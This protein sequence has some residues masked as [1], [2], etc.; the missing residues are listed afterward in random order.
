MV[1][2]RVFIP[3]LELK[4]I[5]ENVVDE[6]PSYDNVQIETTYIFGT[7]D[8]LSQNWDA[9]ILVARGMTHDV[10]RDMFPDKHVVQIQ[11][12][13]F[14]IFD[15]LV[16]CRK[17]QAKKIALCL[18]NVE[19]HN[20]DSLQELCGAS[21]RMYDVADEQSAEAAVCEAASE[22]ADT[23]VGA[24]TMCG[25][26]DRR[27][28]RRVHIH[29][30]HDAV[31][32]AMQEALNA[33]K[34][35]NLE[36]T[37]SE[38]IN[39]MLN[40][41]EDGIIAIDDKGRILAI[42]N[43]AYRVFQLSTVGELIGQPLSSVG[44]SGEWKQLLENGSGK[45][46]IICLH[47][48]KYYVQYKPL[49]EMEAGAGALIFIKN[50]DRIIE[51]ESRI[52]R[53][54]S[55]KGLTAKYTFEDILGQSAAIRENIRMA[56]RYSGV[57]SNVLIIGETGTGKELFAHSIHQ[58]SKRSHQP[59][60]AL[61]CAALP[62][63]LL[64]SELFGYEA[65]AFSGASKGGKTGLFEL[66]HKGTIF[67]DEIGEIPITL[68]AKLLRVLQEKEIRRIG[69]TSVHPVDVRVISAT[70]INMEE[71]IKE[72]QFRSD[73]YYRLNLLDI[74]I[75]P[76]RERKEDIQEL[77]DHYL[78]RFAC[79]MGKSIPTVTKDAARILK[80]HSW[81]GNV[82]ELRN[83]C[84]RLTVLNDTSIIDEELL[85]R[86]KIFRK[87]E[88]FSVGET[89]DSGEDSVYDRLKP[90]KKKKD[91]AEELGVSRTTLWRMA[92]RQ[93]ELEEKQ[94]EQKKEQR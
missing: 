92:K 44:A 82:R 43:Q 74:S 20:L 59:F 24:G 4:E 81:P 22:G 78:T 70:N 37:R 52:R 55:E 66:A 90:R 87:E 40:H 91:L 83:I 31:V 6:L 56:E 18:H 11:L 14:D 1:K 60:V 26:C 94:K 2:I 35:I 76:L 19:I 69:S 58:A 25:I 77:V 41:N 65:G 51:E 34:T 64:E 75:P 9:D 63:N 73:L 71:K 49:S 46:R 47:D 17:L 3:H 68:Q 79:E 12:S 72:G 28:L 86:L 50:T 30:K 8:V 16:Q 39:I 48:K 27:G 80:E 36:R 53:G 7:P 93:K 38:I 32:A 5:F 23:F 42:N 85:C 29:T 61:N 15:A 54:L 13:S 89:A 57:N 88:A 10:L 45:D 62:E 21:I 67:L 84:E 33:A